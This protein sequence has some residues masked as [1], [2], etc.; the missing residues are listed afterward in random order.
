MKKDNTFYDLY[1]AYKVTTTS[2]G[3]RALW[4][5]LGLRVDVPLEFR[6]AKIVMADAWTFLDDHLIYEMLDRGET[7]F[8]V[9]MDTSEVRDVYDWLWERGAHQQ[10][11]QFF[12]YDFL[13]DMRAMP[14]DEFKELMEL[15]W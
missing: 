10:L 3:I 7:I 6:E 14:E 13:D 9:N 8:M 15:F 4:K 11:M 1:C 12:P 2:D 5:W